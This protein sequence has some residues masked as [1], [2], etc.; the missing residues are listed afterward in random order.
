MS[1]RI[2]LA[3]DHPLILTG[4]RSLIEK[5][6]AGGEVVAEASS[7][8]ELFSLLK[9]YECELLISDMSMPSD[10]SKDG[11]IMFK[12]LRQ[13]YPNL[14]II[15]LTQIHNGAILRAL[16][17]V[18]VNSII[19]KKSLNDELAHAI[20][21]VLLGNCYIS[22]SLGLLPSHKGISFQKKTLPSLTAKESE[23]IRLLAS[24]MSVTQVANH[25]HR[26]IKT[27]SSQKKS[28]MIKL[29]IASDGA[30]FEYTRMSGLY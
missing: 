9:Q 15:V 30:L 1:F 26:S 7:V 11:L 19:S 13:E 14:P 3:D 6:I 24:G 23:V 21:E 17:N 12:R 29:N 16:V 28:A 25:L 27:I 22:Q 20:S 18:G 2:I 10:E 5:T 8:S 4:V